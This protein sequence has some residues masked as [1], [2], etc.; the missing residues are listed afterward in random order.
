MQKKG[1]YRPTGKKVNEPRKKRSRK[2]IEGLDSSSALILAAKKNFSEKGYDGASLKDIASEAQ[3]NV[4]LVSYFF[5]GKAG[6][7]KR[8]LEDFGR[9]NLQMAERVLQPPSSIEELRVRLRLFYE[10]ILLTHIK[11]PE[12]TSILHRECVTHMPLIEDV[13]KSTFLKVFD[14]FVQ[15]IKQAQKSKVLRSDVDPQMSVMIFFGALT[16][17]GRI[18]SISQKFFGFSLENE[19]AREKFLDCITDYSIRALRSP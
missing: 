15:F 16:N 9:E 4:G 2:E 14:T 6:L 8:C 10:Q 18:D 17:Q 11:E 3:V 12:I 7:Y 19:K 13:F 5:G 1:V